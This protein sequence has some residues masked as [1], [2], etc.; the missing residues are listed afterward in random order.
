MKSGYLFQAGPDPGF[1]RTYTLPVYCSAAHRALQAPVWK[2]YWLVRPA[3]QQLLA[4]MHFAWDGAA[5][6]SP[7]RAPFGAC[8]F[9]NGLPVAEVKKF[10]DRTG[11][12]LQLAGCR[13]IRVV[14]PPEPYQA[15]GAWAPLFFAEGGYTLGA[16]EPAAFL[17][18]SSD[19]FRARLHPWERRKIRQAAAAGIACNHLEGNRLQDVYRFLQ[20]CRNQRGQQLSMS[21]AQI[22]ALGAGFPDQVLLFE[23]TQ[24]SQRVAA[25]LAIRDHPRVLYTFYCG[26]A[27]AWNALSPLV[28]LLE[29]VHGYC[30]RHQIDWINLGTSTVAGATS[31]PLLQFKLNLGALLFN[32]F[33]FSKNLD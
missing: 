14:T 33:T 19:D 13:H 24:H 25:V 2:S 17:P 18:V 27:A 21:E 28:L 1:T 12:E 5:A 32:K 26:H 15:A 16:A 8:V 4:E 29:Y 7:A 20:L 22:A 11:H 30:R 6:V 10:L 3:A 31:L 9:G 23:A